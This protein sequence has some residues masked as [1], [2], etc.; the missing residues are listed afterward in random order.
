MH[1]QLR[2]LS[3]LPKLRYSREMIGYLKGTPLIS[4][5]SCLILISGVGYAVICT[6]STQMAIEGKEEVELFIHP[7]I[8]EDC[9]D[10]YGFQSEAE[11]FVF[12]K[13]ID[14]DGVGPKTALGIM[15]RGVEAI[16]GAIRTADVSFFSAVP[17]VGKKSAQKIIIELKNKL[18]G[19]Q[20]LDL[21]GVTGKGQE[22]V[23]ALVSLGFSETESI[24]VAKTMDVENSRL[25]DTVKEAIKKLT[26]R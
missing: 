2:S 1:L 3:Q 6:K 18:G 24:H 15:E 11:K 25:E 4:P 21:V 5:Q 19:E 7:H 13:L 14:V 16:T 23:D 12:L 22:V 10:L 17:R 20:E 9:F 8:K 26:N